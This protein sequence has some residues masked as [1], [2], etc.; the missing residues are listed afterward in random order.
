MIRT[1]YYLENFRT[2]LETVLGD[3][4]NVKLYDSKDMAT[5]TNFQQ[6]TGIVRL[7]IYLLDLNP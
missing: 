6:L 1:P 7:I 4:D 5:I 2:I 3:E